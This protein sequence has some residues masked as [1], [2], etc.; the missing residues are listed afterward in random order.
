LSKNEKTNDTSEIIA[1]IG[2]N[3]EDVPWSF[4]FQSYLSSLGSGTSMTSQHDA[5]I[6]V[7]SP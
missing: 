1:V 3:S 5:G 6:Q 7:T 2:P 4:I